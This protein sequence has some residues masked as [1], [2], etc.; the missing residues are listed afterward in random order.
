MTNLELEQ[1]LHQLITEERSLTNEILELITI[2][3]DRKIYSD[4]GYPSMFEWLTTGFG[5]SKSA[6]FRRIEAAKLLNEV[7]SIAAKLQAGKVNLS[8]LCKTQ[9]VLRNEEERCGQKISLSLKEQVIESI[10]HQSVEATE[11]ILFGLFPEAASTV[12][13]ERRTILDPENTRFQITL[14]AKA[15][16]DLQRLK[17][18]LSHRLPRSNAADVIGWALRHTV[19]RM[20]PLEKKNN[21]Y[22]TTMAEVGVHE[23]LGLPN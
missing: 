13:Q 17:E 10:Q 2:A 23:G 20:D 3:K 14:G 15:Q 16:S 4:L 19:K 6:A 12:H 9:G 11:R 8:T 22:R 1:R 5:Y 7:P 18:L 21:P